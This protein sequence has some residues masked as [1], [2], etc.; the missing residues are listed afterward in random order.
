VLLLAGSDGTCATLYSHLA[1]CGVVQ[2]PPRRKVLATNTSAMEFFMLCFLLRLMFLHVF[3]RIRGLRFCAA[4]VVQSPDRL[5]GRHHKP[6]EGVVMLESGMSGTDMSV[7]QLLNA[8]GYSGGI[9][10]CVGRLS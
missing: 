6:L 5:S 7:P 2:Q 1:A 3:R 4:K 10:T 9:E 8:R